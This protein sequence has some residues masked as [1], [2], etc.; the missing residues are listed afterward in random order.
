MP[1]E[2]MRMNSFFLLSPF[3]LFIYLSGKGREKN[4][5][6]KEGGITDDDSC[7]FCPYI[8]EQNPYSPSTNSGFKLSAMLHHL[9]RHRERARYDLYAREKRSV[10]F[11]SFEKNG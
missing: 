2:R 7:S 9:S 11:R 1:R 8:F 3:C 10:S 4:R 5:N 6:K